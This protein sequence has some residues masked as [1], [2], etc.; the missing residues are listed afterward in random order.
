MKLL[1]KAQILTTKQQKTVTTTVTT[2]TVTTKHEKSK[3]DC[4]NKQ[5]I[6]YIWYISGHLETFPQYQRFS[7]GMPFKHIIHSFLRKKKKY[8]FALTVKASLDKQSSISHTDKLR[9][10]RWCGPVPHTVSHRSVTGSL[11]GGKIK[12]WRNGTHPCVH[13]TWLS[14]SK[15]CVLY[16]R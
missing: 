1:I 14:A 2:K 11:G 9:R 4:I 7:S 15:L 12:K 8:I 13:C 10:N 3:E 16:R 6:I 5:D